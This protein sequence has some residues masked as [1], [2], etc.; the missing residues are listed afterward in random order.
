MTDNKSQKIEDAKPDK[1]GQQ[2]PDMSD[3]FSEQAA[4]VTEENVN[5][6]VENGLK[7]PT[8]PDENKEQAQDAKLEVLEGDEQD[9]NQRRY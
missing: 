9:S 5:P 1:E 4:L 8:V 6:P 2:G 3:T 7:K